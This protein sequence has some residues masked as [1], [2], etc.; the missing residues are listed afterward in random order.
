MKEI[1]QHILDI[2]NNSVRAR[3]TLIEISIN[4]DIDN[5]NFVVTIKDNGEGIP[6]DKLEA[7]CDPFVTSRTT[8]KVGLGIPLLKLNA[9][10]TN[11]SFCIESEVGKGT[12]L[13]AV[14]KHKNVDRPVIGDIAGVITMLATTDPKIDVV[15]IHAKQSNEYIFDT[16]EI[17]NEL[18]DV[19]ISNPQIMRFIKE[20]IEE[21]LESINYTK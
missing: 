17:K 4:E 8:R 10:R 13:K 3:A 2:A 19:L 5:D 7:V 20:M 16:R 11:G 12:V 14:F 15:Y 9:E 18:N 6:E 1:A 21:N